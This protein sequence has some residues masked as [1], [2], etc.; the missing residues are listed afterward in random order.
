MA[1]GAQTGN[2]I[3]LVMRQNLMLIGSG[4]AIGIVLSLACTR[5][6]AKLLFGVSAV[7]PLTFAGAAG[8]L[9]AVALVASYIPARRATRVDPMTALRNE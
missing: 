7:D 5:F 4:T 8:T 1:L 9:A 6:L 2:V 3:E